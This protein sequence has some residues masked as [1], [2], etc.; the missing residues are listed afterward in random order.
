MYGRMVT[1]PQD[2]FGINGC[3]AI[4]TTKD[5]FVIADQT[6]ETASQWNPAALQNNYFLH[7]WQVI[8]AS[9]F[10][11]AIMF[12]TGQDDEVIY[13]SEPPTK[14][15]TLSITNAD[16]DT[17]TEATRATVRKAIVAA[18]KSNK[19]VRPVTTEAYLVYGAAH[20][21]PQAMRSAARG[22]NIM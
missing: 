13:V 7:H 12:T 2:R 10:V 4:L 1:I 19:P 3:Q 9:R 6:F 20:A 14:I 17:V 22:G 11:P 21:A 16:G 5:F 8:S 15:N 18:V